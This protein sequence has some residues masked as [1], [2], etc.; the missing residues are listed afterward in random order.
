MPDTDP[1]RELPPTSQDGWIIDNPDAY[2]FLVRHDPP[3]PG[4]FLQVLKLDARDSQVR[5]YWVTIGG[6][7][8]IG[9]VGLWIGSV[10]GTP[11]LML[12]GFVAIGAGGGL[13]VLLIRLFLPAVRNQRLGHL[14]RGEIRSLGPPV[15]ARGCSKTN[16]L[17][18]D[19]RSILVALSN[20]PATE[21]LSRYGR[22]EVL[23]LASPD[24]KWGSVIAI[25]AVPADH[26]E[27]VTTVEH[28]PDDAIDP[29]T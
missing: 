24:E 22:A 14:L 2:Q 13:L 18:S 10:T 9:A 3:R 27:V 6:L 21:L 7:V 8:G 15:L 12:P 17:L 19:G 26:R 29:V 11:W 16:A 1:A 4:S 28:S 5:R 20:T 25:R 23:L